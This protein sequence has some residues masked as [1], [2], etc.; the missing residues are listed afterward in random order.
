MLMWKVNVAYIKNWLD[1]QDDET[2][3]LIRDAIKILEV[4]GP[5]LRR[6]FVGKIRGSKFKNMKE[7]RPASPGGSEIR[8]LFAFDP[9]R[10]AVMLLAGDKANVLGVRGVLKWSAWYRWAL[11][12][13][14]ELFAQHL[15]RLGEE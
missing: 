7:L 10:S 6:P 3:S 2:V 4:D 1:A 9:S 15:A 14:D 8:I 12:R 11:P 5:N 13:A